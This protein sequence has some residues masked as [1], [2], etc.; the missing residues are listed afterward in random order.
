MDNDGRKD[1]SKENWK[2]PVGP[3]KPSST[4]FFLNGE[5]VRLVHFN[6]PN[7]I[8]ELYNFIKDKDQTMLYSDFKKHRKRAYGVKNTLKI[9]NRSRP[10]FE[11][12]VKRGLVEPPIG[13]VVG[14]KRVF[15]EMAYYSEDD[16][17]TIRSVLA[18]IHIGR[19][20]RDGRI[21]AAKDIPTEKELRSLIGD[22]IM[23]YTRTKDGEYIPV[24]AEET[25]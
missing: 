20:R 15:G 4:I 17:F 19:P 3:V 25:W 24:W 14:G 10:Q 5:L 21:N 2:S 1:K 9:F 13:A 6:R 16:L 7:N 18:T 12:W 23:L 11:R 8:C 22:A